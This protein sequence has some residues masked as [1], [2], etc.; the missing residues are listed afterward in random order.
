MSTRSILI[1]MVGFVIAV[2]VFA[3]SAYLY[4]NSILETLGQVVVY[5]MGMSIICGLLLYIYVK[6]TSRSI[7]DPL[8]IIEE[9]PED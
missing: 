7:F 3:S 5:L 8:D 1:G 2:M 9:I 6:I 4:S